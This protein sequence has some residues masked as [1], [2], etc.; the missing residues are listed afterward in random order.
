MGMKQIN[1]K[2]FVVP[3]FIA[4]FARLIYKT[5]YDNNAKII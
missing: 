1:K 5:L 3:F 4:N 2:C